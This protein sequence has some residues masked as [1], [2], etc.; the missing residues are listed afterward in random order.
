MSASIFDYPTHAP[1]YLPGSTDH[2]LLSVSP[3][4][5]LAILQTS[6]SKCTSCTTPR[7]GGITARASL[8]TTLS[9]PSRIWQVPARASFTC[10]TSSRS[11]RVARCFHVKTVSQFSALGITGS[12][13]PGGTSRNRS[14]S[15][16]RTTTAIGGHASSVSD[17]STLL[18]RSRGPEGRRGRVTLERRKQ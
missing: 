3:S 13:T 8:P 5:M 1:P 12:C 16:A 4:D 7:P 15:D 9:A 6:E 10:I 11:P 18:P 2:L 17:G 14:A